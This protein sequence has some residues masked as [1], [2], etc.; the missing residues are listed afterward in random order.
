MPSG[1]DGLLAKSSIIL[2]LAVFPSHDPRPTITIKTQDTN[3][4]WLVDDTIEINFQGNTARFKIIDD[5]ANNP[6]NPD[7]NH[8]TVRFLEYV[9]S[10]VAPQLP[11]SWLARLVSK[12]GLYKDQFV[13]FAL[14]YKYL[15]DEY[16]C[17]S[18]YSYPAFKP[19]GY[20][21]NALLGENDGMQN[22]ADS[23]ILYDF[24]SSD[25]PEDV[26]EIQILY[27][28]T[29]G[30][31]AIYTAATVKANSTHWNAQYPAVGAPGS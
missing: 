2:N 28:E 15:D 1:L 12:S 9:S 27:R 29:D 7:G 20:S 26:E 30:Y 6:S 3:V 22:K 14:R 21:L 16:S 5:F 25:I 24:V 18:P 31:P 10:Y 4:Y 13:K 23:F 19:G 17:I 8:F 11:G